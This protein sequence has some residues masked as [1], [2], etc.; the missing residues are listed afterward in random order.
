MLVEMRHDGVEWRPRPAMGSTLVAA[1]VGGPVAGGGLGAATMLVAPFSVAAS[2]A[3]AGTLAGGALLVSAGWLRVTVSVERDRLVVLLRGLW[4]T[5]RH[6]LRYRDLRTAKV[7]DP[8]EDHRPP[9]LLLRTAEERLFVAEGAPEDHLHWMV[10]A[11]GEALAT[12]ARREAEEGR[13]FFFHRELPQP[14]ADL[15]SD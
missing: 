4:S 2:V 1:M 12:H 5:R 3:I 8:T 14:L 7:F 15:R 9:G 10:E 13:E 11:I 6:E